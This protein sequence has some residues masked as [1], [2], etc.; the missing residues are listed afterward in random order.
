MSNRIT[1]RF[2]GDSSSLRSSA[3]ESGEA[4]DRM[5]P[6]I[7]AVGLGLV[8]LGA[9]SA[10]AGVVAGAALAGLPL[11]IGGIG[12]ASAVQSEKVK[13]AWGSV[14]DHIKTK[15]AQLDDPIEGQ[16]VAM[17]GRVNA[18]FDRVAPRLGAMF[19]TVA[20]MVGTLADGVIRLV[21]GFVGSA[22]LQAAL[23]AA[24]PFV[25]IFADGLAAMGPAIGQFF[26]NLTIGAGGA[27]TAFQGFFDVINWLIPALGTAL[28]ILAQL[29]PVLGPLVGVG[30]AIVGVVRLWAIAQGILNFVLA[31]N[32]IGIVVMAIAALVGML[33]YAWNTSET[34]RNIVTG[35]WRAVSTAAITAVNWI[36]DKWNWVVRFFGNIPGA[37][38]R[39][40]GSIGS[41]IGGVFKS[42]M[43]MAIDFINRGINSI[44]MLIGGIN[45]INPFGQIGMIPHI[46]R[47]HNGG[48]VPG[49]PGSEQ[50]A[51]LQAGETVIPAGAR[52]G[53]G[54][55][56]V[57]FKGNVDSAFA[58]AFM[59]LVRENKIVIS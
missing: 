46:P 42:A 54:G 1:M 36:I 49:A 13:A 4:L 40:L 11:L 6:K 32:P 3:R 20:P 55:R 14:A 15:M 7:T 24:G 57:T 31:A 37:I 38:G 25:K 23:A 41:I 45:A 17:A 50:L 5:G 56:A 27:T 53:G 59:K 39:A 44:N 8:G 12:I 33:I 43:N 34:F 47:F 48:V 29:L 22:G 30:L 16:L 51:I 21:E 52:V 2:I 28:G 58:T 10:A 19:A 35:V 9:S 18:A 26:G